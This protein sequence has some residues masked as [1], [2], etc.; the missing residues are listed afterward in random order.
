[1]TGL[2]VAPCPRCRQPVV[3]G[4]RKCRACQ[5][6]FDYGASAPP[7]P[8]EQQVAHVVAQLRAQ[9]A[10]QR[11][12]AQQQPQAAPPAAP[13]GGAADFVDSGRFDEATARDVEPDE[14]PGFVD[15]SLFAAFTPKTVQ[16]AAVDGLEQTSQQDVG[17]VF[18]QRSADVVPTRAAEVGEVS[19]EEIPGFVDSSLFAKFTP[20]E[21]QAQ[22]V[23]G[24][25]TGP[26][27]RKAKP[28]AARGAG[29]PAD[30]FEM[31]EIRCHSCGSKSKVYRCRACGTARKLD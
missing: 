18:V 10:A 9:I 21:V 30:D 8:S 23:D 25:E 22:H 14:I 29:E 20:A 19:T 5:Q 16:V 6:P 2:P 31:D 24:L 17:E 27:L 26:A 28:K 3:Y 7:E 1:M 11:A 15:S 13:S 12:Q 4:E